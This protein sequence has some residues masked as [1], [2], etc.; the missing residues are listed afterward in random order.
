MVVG[1]EVN[2]AE[3]CDVP[4]ASRRLSLAM[5][6]AEAPMIENW[7]A[8]LQVAT[9]GGK[10]SE[11][12]HAL[13]LDL[14][15]SALSR[16]PADVAKAVCTTMA[17]T[18]KWFPTLAEMIEE[19]DR[20]ASLR[21]GALA[22]VSHE[23]LESPSAPSSGGYLDEIRAMPKPGRIVPPPPVKPSRDPSEKAAMVA[24]LRAMAD[25]EDATDAQG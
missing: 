21:R 10:R 17:T 5:T 4:G 2:R 24:K 6:P 15:V 3:G 11:A 12:G 9:T 8:A 25:A 22:A 23:P 1:Y 19:A 14:Y 7:L 13:A 18:R 20:M 16:Y